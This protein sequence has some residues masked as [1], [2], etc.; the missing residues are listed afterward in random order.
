MGIRL[1][2]AFRERCK[3][4]LSQLQRNGMLRQGSPVDDLMA[5]VIAETGRSADHALEDA[6]PLCLY[7]TTEE[8][9]EEFIAMVR[10]AKPHMMQKSLP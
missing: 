9:R 6:L 10:E 4:F 7:F 5:F 2:A 1:M 3:E 8:D